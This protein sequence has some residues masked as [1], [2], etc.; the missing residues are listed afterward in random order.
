MG[1]DMRTIGVYLEKNGCLLD[2]A[3]SVTVLGNPVL[4]V[5]WLA[6]KLTQFG[7]KLYEGEIVMTG[8]ICL[9]HPIAPGENYHAV[10]GNHVGDVRVAF[11]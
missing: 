7:T 8:S 9:M 6:N 10:F 1:L 11:I 3:C 5:A 4:S 2:S